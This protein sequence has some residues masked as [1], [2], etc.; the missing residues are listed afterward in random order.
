M[1]TSKT[2]Y[3]LK[4]LVVLARRYASGEVVPISEIAEREN[5]PTKFL[6]T[7]L[8]ELKNRGI[9]RSKRGPGG[10]YALADNPDTISLAAVIRWL[11]G[12]LALVP[13][14]SEYA[15]RPCEECNDVESCG[16]RIVLKEVRDTTVQVL[17][18]K[19]LGEL[20]RRSNEAMRHDDAPMYFI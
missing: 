4:A 2:K 1:L 15:Y 5:I 10:G 14:V 17:Q 3:G 20:V 12:P 19:T 16:I 9:L 8:V 7:I 11:N 6:E 18:T 13:C